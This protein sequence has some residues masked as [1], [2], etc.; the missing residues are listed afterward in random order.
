MNGLRWRYVISAARMWRHHRLQALLS[1]LGVIAGVGGLVTVMAVGQGARQELERAISLLG[2]GTMVVKSIVD[3]ETDSRITMDRVQAVQRIFGSELKSLVP[4]STFQRNMLAGDRNLDDVKVIGT[5][6]DYEQAYQLRLHRGRFITWFDIERTERVCVLGW[7]LARELFPRGQPV[8][9]QVR[10]GRHWYTVVGWL[11]A[12]AQS[13]ADL[14]DFDLPDI[15]RAAYVPISAITNEASRIP[16]DELV[17][18]FAAE[19]DMIRASGAVQRILEFDA[20]GA[21]F[22][23]TMPIELLRQKLRMQRIIQYLL[24]GVTVI[25]LAVGGIGI[26]NIMLVNVIRRRP[27]IGLRRAVGATPR[28]ILA[29]FVTES[30]LVAVAGGVAGVLIGALAAWGISAMF[31]WPVVVGA[32]TLGAGLLVSAVVGICFGS[33]PAMQAASVTPIKTLNQT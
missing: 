13:G 26:M 3:N 28:D 4:I 2:A 30:T 6:R 11:Q 31:D 16:L 14:A 8:G 22:E 24:G 10:I 23:Y 1:I 20:D 18:S 7:A 5:D 32:G 33:Y 15:D 12:D 19:A 9:Q 25:M 21:A 17:L 27:E 29:Q